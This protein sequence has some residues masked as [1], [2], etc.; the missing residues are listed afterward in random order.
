MDSA[1]LNDWMQVIGIFA[2]VASL[3]FVGLQMKQDREIALAGQYQERSA[4]ATEFWNSRLQNAIYLRWLGNLI[5]E[6]PELLD[7]FGENVSAE[8]LATHYVIARSTLVRFDNAH[9][10]YISGFYNDESWQ[11]FRANLL[12]FL[13]INHMARYIIRTNGEFFRAS[14]R[15]LCERIIDEVGSDDS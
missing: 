3:L 4:E 9:F 10:Q 11:A 12:R 7:A 13:S 6:N 1:K 15:D 8:E 2:L 14:F 5:V